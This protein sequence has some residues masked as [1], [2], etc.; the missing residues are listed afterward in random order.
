ML[1]STCRSYT[2]AHLPRSF[3][4]RSL[5]L[6]LLLLLLGSSTLRAQSTQTLGDLIG[7]Q[8]PGLESVTVDGVVAGDGYFTAKLPA[9]SFGGASTV[10]VIA[11]FAVPGAD[12]FA[13]VI[14]FQ[15]FTLP[16]GGRRARAI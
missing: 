8:I 12:G 10:P 6:L 3:A 9:L 16:A 15:S 14:S 1:L 11:G 13:V 2:C 7:W 5:P 4:L